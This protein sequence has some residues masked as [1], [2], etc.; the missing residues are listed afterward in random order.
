M[1]EVSASG[2]ASFDEDHAGT[3]FSLKDIQ[4]ARNARRRALRARLNDRIPI[5]ATTPTPPEL[6]A[7]RVTR[8]WLRTYAQ[9]E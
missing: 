4:A 3:T 1:S 9:D 5:T 8:P 6:P 2:C 7:P